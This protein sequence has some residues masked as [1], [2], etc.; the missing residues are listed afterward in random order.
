MWEAVVKAALTKGSIPLS[1]MVVYALPTLKHVLKCRGIKA[2]EK[3][4]KNF[5]SIKVRAR[6][7]NSGKIYG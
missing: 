4:A 6:V 1:P 3:P 2:F 7:G 5:F